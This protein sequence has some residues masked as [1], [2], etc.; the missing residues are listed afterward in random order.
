MSPEQKA[1]IKISWRAVEPIAE[2]A[3]ALFYQRLFEV[4]PELRA[5]FS[6]TDMA[7]Q[8]SKLIAALSAVV[9]SVDHLE[10]VMPALQ[11]LGRRHAGYGVEFEHYDTVGSALLWTLEQGLG[12]RWTPELEAAWAD[13]YALVAGVMRDAQREAETI[14]SP[15]L[16]AT[17]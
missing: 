4:D 9:A 13:A 5:L 10:R 8:R 12:E 17:A 2:E 14:V 15:T 16:A 6:T 7:K 1:L 11:S 3:A